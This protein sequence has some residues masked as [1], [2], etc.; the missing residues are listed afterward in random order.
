ML[1]FSQDIFSLPDPEAEFNKLKESTADNEQKDDKKKEK[2]ENQTPKESK[3]KKLKV[4]KV[5][6]ELLSFLIY[7]D[8]R[9]L[10]QNIVL[11]KFLCYFINVGSTSEET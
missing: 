6:E 10:V 9:M 4:A 2:K 5:R 11:V 7:T 8:K 1:I 3:P